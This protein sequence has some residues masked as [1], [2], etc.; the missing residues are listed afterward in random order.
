MERSEPALAP[1]WLRNTGSVTGGGN[2]A[3]HFASSSHSDVSS[4]AP[5]ARSRTSKI[6]SELETRSSFLDR[7]SSSNSRRSSSNGSAKHA[8]SSF[9]R[10]HRD[11]DREK[12]KD[13]FGDHWD[14]DSSDPLGNIFNRVEKDT[15]RRS[16][17][18]VSR[19]PGEQLSRR[20]STDL[21]IS[22]N[23]NHSNG[24]GTL[25]GG[26]GSSIQK[27]VFE[28]DF[29]SLGTEERQG[30]PDIGRVSSPGF[31]TAVQSLPVANSSLVGGEGWTSALIEAPPKNGSSGSG[32]FTVQQSVAAVTSGSG[33]PTAMAG[34]NMAEAL[35]QAP[36]RTRAAPQLSVKTQRLEELAIKQSRQLIPVT[37]SLPKTLALSS[38]KSKPKPGARTGEMNAASKS[39]Q[40]QQS[41]LHNVNQ[42]LRGG[43]MKPDTPKTSHGKFLVL[44]PVRE[45]GV[46]LSSKDITSPTYNS[47]TIAFNTQVAAAPPVVSAPTRSPNSQKV[48]SLE[49]KVAAL[50]LKTG[51]ALEKKP[52]LSQSQ[53]RNDFFNLIKKKTSVNP[54]T[55]LPNSGPHISSPTSEKSGE[56]VREAFS[57]PASPHT[58][59]NGAEVNGNGNSCKQIQRFS[60]RGDDECPSAAL[61]LDEE[62]VKFL[63]SLGWDE[64]AAEDEGLTE[65]EISAFYEEC[66]KKGS[67]SLKVCRGLQP[68]FPTLPESHANP[69]GASSE[70]SSS[71][72]GSDA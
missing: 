12:E 44:K 49:R 67:S 47:S 52:S 68:K 39:G 65:E 41:S 7:S 48:P 14:R 54:S 10:S 16:Q 59:E 63:R 61:Y 45:N 57:A 40:Q 6:L 2:S 18:L 28:K 22:S 26:L 51:T 17:S 29:P 43:S 9:N 55:V 4:L 20:V 32:S 72:S 34:L 62:E 19:K 60:D 11:K 31:T 1:Q 27:A 24:N 5:H 42:Y 21:K 33:A 38:E 58:V 46:S 35:A 8:Y 13:R 36:S 37:P 71:D 56:E 30:L 69:G 53:S 25:S 50:D 15:L 3:H 64:N 66:M 70:L 23:S